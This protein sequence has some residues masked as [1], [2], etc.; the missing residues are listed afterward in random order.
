MLFRSGPSKEHGSWGD[1]SL[2]L[3]AVE[4]YHASYVSI[5]WW[6][7]EFLDACRPLIERMNRRL[8]YRLQLVKATFPSRVI[9]R[10]V[11]DVDWTW[12]NAGVA[13]CLPG[14]FPCLTLTDAKGGIVAVM[15]DDA[16]DAR[17]LPEGEPDKAETRRS[18]RAF[19]LP[20]NVPSGTYDAWVSVGTRTGTPSIALPLAD[21]LGR[22]YKLGRIAVTG[23]FAVTAGDLSRMGDGN[24][25]QIPLVYT[26]HH[27]LPASVAPFVHFDAEGKIAFQGEVVRAPG[28]QPLNFEGQTPAMLRFS[29]PP[30]ARGKRFMLWIGLYDTRKFA[31]SDERLQPDGAGADHRLCLGEIEVRADGT[32]GRTLPAAGQ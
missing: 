13:P 9:Q 3:K 28:S 18:A 16:L 1:G 12:R 10:G 25:W 32:V 20:W 5:H 2:Y 7:R 19:H 4:E 11:I 15:V 17:L 23:D 14:G 30:E 26:K 8:G 31:T 22:R 27:A 24:D 29:P 6:P 21:G